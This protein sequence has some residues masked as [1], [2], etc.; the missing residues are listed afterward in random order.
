MVTAQN[1]GEGKSSLT[2]ALA[3]RMAALSSQQELNRLVQVI[4]PHA[5]RYHLAPKLQPIISRLN[6]EEFKIAVVANMSSGKSSFINALFG[7]IVLPAFHEATTGCLTYIYPY[8][9]KGQGRARVHFSHERPAVEISGE[10]VK[11]EIKFYAQQ[12]SADKPETY[13]HVERIDLFWEFETFKAMERVQFR[14]VVIDTPGPNNTGHF[15]Q[16]HRTITNR[17]IREDADLVIFLFD[18]G[19]LDANL[20]SDQQGLWEIIKKRSQND[21]F[22]DVLFIINKAD[23]ALEDDALRNLPQGVS[24]KNAIAKLQSTALT[25]GFEAPDV[26]GVASHFACLHK[27]NQKGLLHLD[28]L[29]G[30]TSR[31]AYRK[32]LIDFDDAEDPEAALAAY[33]G[34]EAI[35]RRITD[36]IRSTVEDKVV[37]RVRW[38]LEGVIKEIV[39]AAQQRIGFL[40]Q[41][42]E[43]AEIGL[44]K[45]LDLLTREIPYM[46]EQLT[47]E[48]NTHRYDCLAESESVIEACARE[49]LLDPLS[50]LTDQACR[51][52]HVHFTDEM[53]WPEAQHAAAQPAKKALVSRDGLYRFTTA[54][55]TVTAATLFGLIESYISDRLDR[56]RQD[57][58]NA[59]KLK[60]EGI[61]KR[62]VET[63]N[64]SVSQMQNELNK[65]LSAA[66]GTA[67]GSGRIQEMGDLNIPPMNFSIPLSCIE[68][69]E[70]E[71]LVTVPDGYRQEQVKKQRLMQRAW[72]NPLRWVG[73]GAYLDEYVETENKAVFKTRLEKEY[74]LTID[75]KALREKL[76]QRIR[77]GLEA[78]KENDT[79]QI[80]ISLDQLMEQYISFFD[81]M[82]NEKR[83]EIYGLKADLADQEARQKA[84][85]ESF[86]GFQRDLQIALTPTP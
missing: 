40:G 36:Y 22:F 41:T 45:G 65:E 59:F 48:F 74:Q 62:F 10:Q 24:L 72:Y 78:W 42:A 6:E 12:D 84:E 4:L 68:T 3:R 28:S 7:D 14:Y 79:L 83:T 16:S 8:T 11:Q 30:R 23:L 1:R 2:S 43:K 66:L 85:I 20:V 25:H 51:A 49:H 31:K 32:A 9:I 53:A 57:A 52:V 60:V 39:N 26:Y 27:M 5:S 47:G 21:P 18:Y 82:E 55:P 33:Q 67:H 64:E 81:S 38:E 56:A 44:R 70:K 15:S 61:F 77:Q 73:K 63:L 69:S 13:R 19:Q 17:L 58:L 86:K 29:E 71:R 50:D 75:P 76:E 37:G 80:Y 34:I 46:R 35:E 54:D